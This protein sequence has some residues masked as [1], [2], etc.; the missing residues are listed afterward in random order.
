LTTLAQTFAE[1]I[2]RG[3][4]RGALCVIRGD[5]VLLDIWGGEASLGRPWTEDTI[6]CCFSVTKGVLSLLAHVLIDK[7]IITLETRIVEVWPE[8]T[9]AEKGSITLLDVLTHRAGLPAVSGPVCPGDLY[10]WDRMVA[11][12][13]ASDPVV[14]PRAD[15]VYHNMTYGHLLGET[16]RR[17]AGF[18]QALPALLDRFVT[19][20]LSADFRLALGASDQARAAWLTQDDPRSLFQTLQSAPDTIFARS[21]A[22]FDPREDFNSASW[23]GAAIASGSGHA[24]ARAIA[25]L[26]GRL[27]MPGLLSEGRRAELREEQTRSRGLDPVLGLPIRYCQGLELSTPPRLDFGPSSE[28]LGH[29]GA[30][31]ATGLADPRTGLSMGYVTGRMDSALGSSV[32]GRRLVAALF[33]CEVP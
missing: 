11:H 9:G 19:G 2:E 6:G 3:E 16:L 17:A 18:E 28:S 8:F 5:E 32:R 26:Y 21:M 12:L 13:A 31:G 30:G 15:P 20:P 7:G 14:P 27:V 23:R 24:T 33:A 22:F 1:S 25:M 10:S 4:E 29:W